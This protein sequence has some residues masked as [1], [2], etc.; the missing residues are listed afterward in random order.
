MKCNTPRATSLWVAGLLSALCAV[1]PAEAADVTATV[2]CPAD[3]V[4]IN[5]DSEGDRVSVAGCTLR[6]EAAG[7]PDLPIRLYRLIIPADLNVT[8]ALVTRV[9]FVAIESAD[10]A[11]RIPPA[12]PP[13]P[14]DGSGDPGPV[15]PDP[16]IYGK[17]VAYPAKT[18]ELVGTEYCFGH[19]IVTLLVHPLRYYPLSGRLERL[20][21]LEFE[22]QGSRAAAERFYAQRRSEYS[23]AVV[24]ETIGRFVENDDQIQSFAPPTRIERLSE[25]RGRDELRTEPWPSLEG[26]PVDYVIITSSALAASFEPLAEWKQQK[27]MNTVIRTVSNIRGHYPGVDAQECLRHFIIEAGQLWGA[28]WVL[29]GGDVNQ[30]PD[31]KVFC[32]GYSA[33]VPSDL[34]FAT[35]D[36]NWNANGNAIFGENADQAD[37]S[38]DFHVGRAPV[39]DLEEAELFVQKVLNYEQAP[40]SNFAATYLLMGVTYNCTTSPT[41]HWG[42]WCKEDITEIILTNS[43]TAFVWRLYNFLTD[44]ETFWGDELLNHDSAMAHLNTGYNFVNHCDHSGVYAM[45]TGKYCWGGQ[46]DP[47]DARALTNGA[48]QG[49]LLTLGCSP[50]AFDYDAISEDFMNNP[51]GGVVAY[52]GNTRTGY[53]GQV[54]Q[55]KTFFREVLQNEIFNLGAAFSLA[56]SDTYNSYYCRVL[57]LLGDPEMVLWTEEPVN[58]GV[59]HPSELGIGP[60]NVTIEVYE[61]LIWPPMPVEGAH[62]CLYKQDEIYAVE[63]TGPT[64]IVS[65]DIT[66]DTSAEPVRLTVTAVNHLPYQADLPITSVALA[67]HLHVSGYDIDDDT[68]GASDGNA[69]GNPD[70]GETIEIPLNVTNS[71]GATEYDV[72]VRLSSDTAEVAVLV[73]Q[74]YVGDIDPGETVTTGSF[75]IAVDADCPPETLAMLHV[76]MGPLTG[77]EPHLD[78]FWFPLHAPDLRINDNVLVDDGSGQSQGNGNGVAEPSETVEL[79]MELGNAGHGRARNVSAVA[80]SD[81]P[82]LIVIDG[83]TE[84]GDIPAMCAVRAGDPIVVEISPDFVGDETLTLVVSDHYIE[85]ATFTLDLAGPPAPSGLAF[86]SGQ[87]W[88]DLTW[89]PVAAGDLLGYHV[90]RAISPD[91]VFQRLDVLVQAGSSLYHDELFLMPPFPEFYYYYVTAVDESGNESS[92]SEILQAWTTHPEYANWPIKLGGKIFAAATVADVD[93]NGTME[94]FVGGLDGK[95][96]GFY[97]DGTEMF[98]LDNDPTTV[99]GFAETES[100]GGVWGAPSI[101]DLDRDGSPDV[102]ATSR[103]NEHK[104]YAWRTFDGDGDGAPD[105]LPGWPVYLGADSGKSLCSPAL[106]DV[107]GDGWL[108]VVFTTEC[109]GGMVHVIDGRGFEE[110]GWPQTG[111]GNWTYATPALGDLDGQLEP[112]LPE[113]IVGGRSGSIYAWHADGSFVPGW[114][115]ATGGQIDSSPALGDIDGD[116]LLEIIQNTHNGFLYAFEADGS[117]V[118]GWVGGKSYAAHDGL[119]A[120]PALA[121]IDGDN[122]PEVFLATDDGVAAWSPDGT[123]LVGWPVVLAAGEGSRSSTAVADI[124]G[125]L[126]F[127]IVVGSGDERIYAIEEDGSLSPHWP[128]RAG[129]HVDAGPTLADIDGDGDMEII[130]GAAYTLHVWDCPEDY[131]LKKI[132]WGTFHADVAHTGV[133]NPTPP[134]YGTGDSDVDGDVDLA[135]FADFQVCAECP[136]VP[137]DPLVPSCWYFDFEPNGM[138][139]YDDFVVLEGL[140]GGPN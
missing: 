124:D 51:N 56:R 18:V 52:M 76:E 72:T 40:P 125:D 26:L 84:F 87:D 123:P 83:Q 80:T 112:E 114:P 107:D 86:E 103:G 28:P 128:A 122:L 106:G 81:H 42:Q 31:R 36:G 133:Y 98:D 57:N 19:H 64:G 7:K 118:L 54:S 35:A 99:S 82:N 73:D 119:L 24:R 17:D 33:D 134:Q 2:G 8:E 121:D 49:V 91:G 140:F 38:V 48:R 45:G 67:P 30:V 126:E 59:V 9:E 68:Q 13:L 138:V 3:S 93:F 61:A 75:V 23:A 132:Q 22:V 62:V 101:G 47:D 15:K 102:V 34:Y 113:I 32:Q 20:D 137:T 136:D 100:T 94:I 71:G 127:E 14:T 63:T 39:E 27:G 10:G 65:M 43:P 74:F 16:D 120:S 104:V 111:L 135:D 60:Q 5:R 117:E 69:D 4:S 130:V 11:F 25:K 78:D 66:C 79:Y 44:D 29:L 139:N 70:V 46:L 129:E 96:Y 131:V 6:T 110:L 53:T 37:E 105:P 58:L 116:H 92:P 50:N 108:E 12:K 1:G 115:V 21:Q 85:R 90:Y 41:Y 97:H 77:K 55:D 88:I 109:G 95:V 89:E